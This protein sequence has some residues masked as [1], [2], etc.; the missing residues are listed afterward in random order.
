M[1]RWLFAGAALLGAVIG[2]VVGWI[3]YDESA[4]EGPL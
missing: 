3:T 2:G 4:P 1:I